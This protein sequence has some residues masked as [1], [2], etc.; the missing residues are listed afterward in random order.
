MATTYEVRFVGETP[1]IMDADNIELQDALNN[2]VRE[3]P[4]ESKAGDDRTPPWRWKTKLH[5]D[6]EV[7]AMPCDMVVAAIS[8]AG[9]ELTLKGRKT[10]KNVAVENICPLDDYYP[11]MIGNGRKH[12]LKLKDI[13]AVKGSYAE[14][15][16]AARKLGFRLFMAR[17][18]PQ[19]KSRHVRIRPRFDEYEFTVRLCVT[20]DMITREVLKQIVERMNAWG[21]WSR[22]QVRP[23]PFGKTKATLKKLKE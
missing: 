10:F 5:T 2:W 7:V 16:A 22:R 18:R 12:T 11:L 4:T 23:G 3:H 8:Y 17:A 19:G 20:G 9:N 13:E 6:G 21:N 14:Q 1:L 15:E